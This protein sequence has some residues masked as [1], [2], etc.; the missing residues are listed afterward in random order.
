[1][2]NGV[3]TVHSASSVACRVCLPAPSGVLHLYRRPSSPV[4][5]PPKPPNYQG[6]LSLVARP[7]GS[8]TFLYNPLHFSLAR[9]AAPLLPRAHIVA[10]PLNPPLGYTTPSIPLPGVHP[11]P[12]SPL[13]DPFTPLNISPSREYNN[14]SN[15]P[16]PGDPSPSVIPTWGSLHPSQ[17]I[18]FRGSIYNPL[19]PPTRGS[20]SS[21]VFHSKITPIPVA[22]FIP[23]YS[24]PPLSPFLLS[25]GAHTIAITV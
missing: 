5:S 1:M 24:N 11:L 13:G 25:R 18:P 16:L 19:F 4:E 12:S 20:R 17:N 10:F 7:P 15:S 21:L 9:E 3:H 23:I 8:L 22:L 2:T 6:G 14:P